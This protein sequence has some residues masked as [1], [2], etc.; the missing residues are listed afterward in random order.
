MREER[1]TFPAIAKYLN[2][3]DYKSVLDKSFKNAHIHNIE[4]EENAGLAK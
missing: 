3:N 2:E 1:T 4:K